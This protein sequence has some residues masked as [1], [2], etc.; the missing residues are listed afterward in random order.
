V[1]RISGHN[2]DEI[3]G[4]HRK[5]NPEELH[6]FPC[7]SYIIRIT[8]SRRMKRTGHAAHMRREEH[9]VFW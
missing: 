1:S 4:G 5:L 7:S 9:A 3:L 8:K 6:E 2:R